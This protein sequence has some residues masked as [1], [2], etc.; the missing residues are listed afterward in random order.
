MRKSFVSLFFAILPGIFFLVSAEEKH[1]EPKLPDPL[2]IIE[3][4]DLPI[5]LS[6]PHGGRRPVPGVV[7]RKG[8][9]V[10]QFVARSDSWT[11]EL[12]EKLADEIEKNT[13]KRPYVVIAKFHR[14]FIDANRPPERAYESKAAKETYDTYH[15]ALA[16][17]RAKV[18]ARWGTGILLDIHGQAAEP[19]TIIRGTRN[20]RTIT[21]L[22]EKFN[23][24]SL[25]SESSLF[26]HLSAQGLAVHPP[27]NSTRNEQTSYSGGYIV[28]TYGSVKGGA[29]DAIQLE[30]GRNLR[31]P[32]VNSE[33]AKK[34]AT[35]ILNFSSQYLPSKKSADAI[36]V[37]V[38][39]D[40]GAG[41][42]KINLLHA[43][44]TF[45]DVSIQHL[46]AKDIQSGKLDQL[47]VLIQPGGSGGGQG[48][49]L[50]ED[51]REKIRHFL[52]NGG[53]YIGI[54]AGAYLASADYSWSLKILD[55]RVVDR[56][57]WAR[58]NGTVNLTLSDSGKD[59]LQT[60]DDSLEIFYAQ[61]PLL[62]PAGNPT[63][64]DYDPVATFQTEIAKKGAPKGVMVGTTA[65]AEGR[66]GKGRVICFSPHP[67]LTKGL[68]HSI[69]LA[70]QKV[71]QGRSN[72]VK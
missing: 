72:K 29:L 41:K 48:R 27:V 45:D 54:C 25:I 71:N 12:T 24:D 44:S 58:G 16:D 70:I 56:K 10:P 38:Y 3:A 57:H 42:S 33:T 55:A 11:D 35:A 68:D 59:L 22:I 4:G 26:G 66:F 34:L 43:L 52:K 37:G 13:G 69:Q 32:T 2:V 30:L 8:E 46:T 63:I 19:D 67:E 36:N 31:R 14:K 39:L 18:I 1:D 17:A 53:G 47:D 51:G 28:G 5:I 7:P 64:P 61:G 20:G 23:R 65:I 49:H 40:K 50:G 21:H 62:T 9:D 60:P 15:K 6:A